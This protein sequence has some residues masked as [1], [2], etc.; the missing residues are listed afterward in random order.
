MCNIIEFFPFLFLWTKYIASRKIANILFS[1]STL[2]LSKLLF[3]GAWVAQFEH[4]PLTSTQVMIPGSW[5][6]APHWTLCLVGSLLLALSVI[7]L[8]LTLSLK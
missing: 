1:K 5:D 7:P 3:R 4:L 6:P 2:S 8:A